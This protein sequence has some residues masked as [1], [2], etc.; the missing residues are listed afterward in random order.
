[1]SVRFPP[2]VYADMVELVPEGERSGLIHRLLARELKR[3]RREREAA[4]AGPVPT[5]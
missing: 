3:L 2:R 1:M 5:G 4:A